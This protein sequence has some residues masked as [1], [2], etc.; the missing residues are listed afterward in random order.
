MLR[1]TCNTLL[2]MTSLTSQMLWYLLKMII[3]PT[4]KIYL[5]SEEV[6]INNLQNLVDKNIGTTCNTLLI[7]DMIVYNDMCVYNLDIHCTSFEPYH[8][9]LKQLKMVLV[10]LCKRDIVPLTLIL[11]IS[12]CSE[13]C[14]RDMDTLHFRML[15]RTLSQW[16]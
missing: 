10:T 1:K 5:D 3:F 4:W 13:H 9:V 8:K 6:R 12:E 2:Y 11:Y 7:E 14:S 16:H 15:T